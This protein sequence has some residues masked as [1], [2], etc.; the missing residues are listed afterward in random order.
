MAGERKKLGQLENVIAGADASSGANRGR[1]VD[2]ARRRATEMGNVMFDAAAPVLMQPDVLASLPKDLAARIKLGDPD[3][4]MEGIM[5]VGR[6]GRVPQNIPRDTQ[7]A[8]NNFPGAE[9]GFQMGA[10]GGRVPVDSAG[11]LVVAGNRSLSRNPGAEPGFSWDGNAGPQ[12]FDSTSLSV[13]RRGEISVRQAPRGGNGGGSKWPWIGAGAGVAAGGKVL[14]DSLSSGEGDV[15]VKPEE[16]VPDTSEEGTLPAV[17]QQMTDLQAQ[18]RAI[19]DRM[20]GNQPPA[21]APRRKPPRPESELWQTQG[22]RSMEYELRPGTPQANTRDVL[23][24]AGI[25]PGRAE[26]IARGIISMTEQ[27][28]RAVVGNGAAR[29]RRTQDQIDERRAARMGNY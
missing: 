11:E 10:N 1:A 29:S 8:R 7:I 19:V 26:G 2:G 20:V 3:A 27:E 28:R 16:S 13:P 6:S 9:A 14:Y 22:E 23:L 12:V 24:D 15:Q 4:I 21:T 17:D 25:E 5:Y 18:A